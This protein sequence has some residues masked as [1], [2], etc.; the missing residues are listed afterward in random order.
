VRWNATDPVFSRLVVEDTELEGEFLPKD[1]ALEICLGAGNRDP[2][3]WDNPDVYDLHRP[4]KPHIGFG[5]GTHLCLG[6]DVARSEINVGLN[7]LLDAFPNL[8]LEP[9]APAPSL[10][11]GLEQ[12]GI[13]A[14]PV[15]L[16]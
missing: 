12:R 2:E 14:L 8:R 13:S 9:D 10:T 16:K 7:A 4:Y 11:G 1:A 6:R 5:V 15:L 3:R